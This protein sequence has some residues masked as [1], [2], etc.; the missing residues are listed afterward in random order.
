MAEEIV[1]IHIEMPALP[2]WVETNSAI[3][4]PLTYEDINALAEACAEIQSRDMEYTEAQVY[5]TGERDI[6][7]I[8]SA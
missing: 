7:F 1:R 8:L 6:V 3:N 2:D 5:F 4:F